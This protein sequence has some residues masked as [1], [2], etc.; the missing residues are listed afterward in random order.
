MSPT[1]K[2]VLLVGAVT[3][4]AGAVRFHALSRPSE[5]VFDE[6]YYASD[7]CWY[8]GEPYR[9]CELESDVER[10]W[11]HPPLGKQIIAIGIDAFGNRPFGWRFSAAVFG[12]GAVALAGILAFLL[13]GSALW[14]AIAALLAGTEHL[15]FVQS[16]IAMLDV[17]L[18]FFILAG[19][20]LLVADR[21][22]TERIDGTIDPD[23]GELPQGR[24]PLR[25][26]SGAAFGAAIAVKWSAILALLGAVV[27]AVAWERSRR[28]AAGRS[29]PLLFAVREEGIW[30]YVAFA[31]VPLAVYLLPWIPWL[32]DRSFD[33]SE[34]VSHHGEMAEY[35]FGLETLKANGEPIH[36][37]MS[38]AWSWLLL[39][40]P[41]AYYWQGEPNCCREILGMGNPALFWGALL[42]IPYLALTWLG[43][44][45]W[46]AGAI[47]IPIV[48]QL[49]PW[50]A[51]GRPQFLFYMTPIAP[52][53]ALGM[54]YPLRDLLRS[55]LDRR[56]AVGAAG[57]VV[58]TC[59]A[60]FAF[61]LPVL[62]AGQLTYEE[63]QT[64][65]WFPGWI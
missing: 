15:L 52:F 38:Q 12:T 40:R 3:L 60:M 35:H 62:A 22:R 55:S 17:F 56:I 51:I 57:L 9:D 54:V 43:K 42:V 33:L 8:A 27:L 19:L 7:A 25:Y 59:V 39:T 48:A 45:E 32:A 11:V 20:V 26:L 4:L 50:L 47:L 44:K 53:L 37:Y 29:R 28:K 23:S 36:P 6:V 24:R 34:L 61:H 64:R 1:R 30:I 2:A 41:V 31:L 5:K 10:S 14:G 65:M 16:R 49:T 13:F 21:R 63:W 18:T 46:Q 58:G